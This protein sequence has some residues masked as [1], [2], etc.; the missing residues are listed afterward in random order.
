[1]AQHTTTHAPAAAHQEHAGH[2]NAAYLRLLAALG[3]SFVV[4]FAIMFARVNVAENVHLSLNN[5]YMAALMVAPMP[6]IMLATMRTMFGNRRLN[7]L[8]VGAAVAAIVLFFV[9]IRTQAGID[10][11]QFLRAMIPHHAGAILVCEQ[12]SLENAEVRR[13]CRQIIA[14]QQ[15]EIVEMKEMLRQ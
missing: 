1:M 14:S 11:R 13:L 6:L 5:A 8:M 15:R 2:G 10:D 3:L 9:L 4:M 12:A 7:R